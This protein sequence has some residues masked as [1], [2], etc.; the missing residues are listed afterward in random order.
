MWD[1]D[2]NKESQSIITV[3]KQ[4]LKIMGNSSL[5]NIIIFLYNTVHS[6]NYSILKDWDYTYEGNKPYRILGTIS[7]I[8]DIFKTIGIWVV[9]RGVYDP[10]PQKKKKKKKKKK[11][12]YTGIFFMVKKFFAAFIRNLVGNITFDC[13]KK[14]TCNTSCI[15]YIPPPPPPPF[16]CS[17]PYP[18]EA[19]H[20]S[21]DKSCLSHH[22]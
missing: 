20:I 22:S 12:L 1:A 8:T 6:K 10:P 21:V 18:S 13:S 19:S 9:P 4:P 11:R 3:G 15:K 14:N 17:I 2:N 5:M 16:S 7:W